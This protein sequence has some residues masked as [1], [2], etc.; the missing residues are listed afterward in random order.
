MTVFCRAPSSGA[1]APPTTCQILV[2][3]LRSRP[4]RGE[5]EAKQLVSE[6]IF[7]S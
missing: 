3:S 5:G 1:T 4:P 7:A 6:D 2:S